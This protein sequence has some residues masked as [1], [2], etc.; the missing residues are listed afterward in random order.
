L[1]EPRWPLAGPL[2]F[3]VFTTF[4]AIIGLLSAAELNARR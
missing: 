1:S 3:I 2:V 4:V